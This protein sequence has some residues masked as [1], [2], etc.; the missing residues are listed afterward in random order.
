[1]R[2]KC[3]ALVRNRSGGIR[4]DSFFDG[5]IG[6]EIGTI[7]GGATVTQSPI[8]S[9]STDVSASPTSSAQTISSDLLPQLGSPMGGRDRGAANNGFTI[10]AAPSTPW[11]KNP[12]IQKALAKGA[13]SAGIDAIGLIPGGGAVSEG[14]SLFHGAAAVSNGTAILGRVQ[15][16]AGIITTANGASNTSPL[17]VTQTALGVGGI[18]AGVAKAAPVVGQVISGLSVVG[19]FVG[20]GLELAQCH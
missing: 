1:M 3:Y 7:S 9:W 11:Y 12:C 4:T 14:L 19:D 16:G 18:V 5:N 17:G 10:S 20:T 2:P 13:V 6:K 15:L 8:D